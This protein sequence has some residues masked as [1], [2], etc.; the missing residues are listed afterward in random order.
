MLVCACFWCKFGSHVAFYWWGGNY[1]HYRC[2]GAN[3]GKFFVGVCIDIKKFC[4]IG[5]TGLIV[6]IWQAGLICNKPVNALTPEAQ[7]IS[8]VIII[9]MTI[10]NKENNS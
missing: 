4:A 9:K 5:F 10:D 7:W 2:L 6:L 3:W 1:C 8:T